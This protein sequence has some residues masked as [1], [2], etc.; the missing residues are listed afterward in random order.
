MTVTT[1]ILQRTFHIRHNGQT[2]TCFTIDVQSK[3]Y[4]ITASHVVASILNDATVEISHNQN[5]IPARVKLVGHC[6]RDI[7]IAVLA[8][9]ELFGSPFP[10]RLTTAGLT[11]AEDVYFLGFPYGMSMEGT[12]LNGGFPLPLAK[13]AAVLALGIGDRPLLLDGHNNSGFSGGPVA[14]RGTKEGQTIV[15]VISGFHGETRK[16]LDEKGNETQFTYTVNTGIVVAHD[17][18]HALAIIETYPIGISV[19]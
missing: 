19:G 4:L 11:L 12:D 18:R 6:A 9:Q 17:I 10:L 1:N 7:D 15:G 14:R 5:W 2:G 8:P 16:V 13:K 3:R